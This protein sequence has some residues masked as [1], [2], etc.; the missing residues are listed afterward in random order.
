MAD[1]LPWPSV[2]VPSSEDWS[3]RGGT[4]SGGQ[5]FQ[6]HEQIVASPTARWRATLTI[7]CMQREQVMAMRRLVALGRT[8]AWAVGPIETARA[9]WNV[10]MIGGKITYGRGRKDAAVNLAFETGPDT[11]SSLDFRLAIDASMNGTTL[12]I[13]R[14]K[15]GVLEVGM[16]F[17]IGGRLH[18]LTDLPAGDPGT[19][20]LQGPAGTIGIGFRPWLRADYTADTPMEFGA[21]VG[22]MRLA[23]DDTG[24][25]ELQLSRHGTVT[26]DLIEAF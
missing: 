3:L 17:S 1:P 26:L 2:L 20:G 21:P 22:L 14:N 24:S 5:T 9:P 6:G 19:L 18:I 15:G 4:R 16:L 12:T 25:A 13:Q 10:D 23:S 8:Q 11:S 7:P